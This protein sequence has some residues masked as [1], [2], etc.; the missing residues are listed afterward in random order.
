MIA[1]PGGIL[2]CGNLVQDILVRPV[3]GVRFDTTTWVESIEMSLGGNGAN[4]SYA[5]ARLG[6]PVQLLGAVGAD[7]F[8]DRAIAKLISAG[9]NVE[10]I[11]RVA[12]QPTATT[13]GLVNAAGARAFFHNPGVSRQ[14]MAEPL[15]FP[16]ALTA[17]YSHFHLANPFALPALRAHAGENLRQARAAGLTTSMDCGWDARGEWLTVAGP[18]LPGLDL[19]FVNQDEARHLSGSAE[20]RTA[21]RFFD[22]HGVHATVVK[23]GAD[24]CFLFENGTETHVPA[25]RIEAVDSTG[26]GDCFAGG[27]LAALHHGLSTH[28]AARLANAAGAL[29]VS[30]MGAVSGLLSFDETRRWMAA[31]L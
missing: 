6:A 1:I 22:E 13:V 3:E 2:C 23:A 28:E 9:V 17:G 29:S 27:F 31:Q 8:G 24:G 11:E 10:R 30:R 14:A 26:A 5:I 7:E 20:A 19:L 15:E 12:D 16:A 21:A 18:C 4:T 25:F